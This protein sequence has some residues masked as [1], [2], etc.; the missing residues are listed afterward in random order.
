MSTK[1]V[2]LTVVT[3]LLTLVFASAATNVIVTKYEVSK[4]QI[5][6]GDEF[7]LNISFKHI[8][9]S[10]LGSNLTLV[11][12]SPADF[13]L[14]DGGSS[15][16]I[17]NPPILFSAQLPL[18][19]RGENNVFSFDI[20]DDA[21][22]E[23]I[24]SDKVV[25]KE[26]VPSDKDDDPQPPVDSTKYKPQFELVNQPFSEPF[27]TAKKYSLII[28]LKNASSYV[29]KDVHLSLEK[30]EDE[31]PFD[32]SSSTLTASQKQVLYQN[33]S[34][35]VL[36]FKLDPTALSK[37]YKLVLKI[38]YK[39]TH[40]DS[41]SQT[42]PVVLEVD[43][44]NV[45]PIINVVDTTV[46][47]SGDNKNVAL[48][49]ANG[50]TLTAQDV[51]IA[52][53]GFSADGLILASD[54]AT[55]QIGNLGGGQRATVDFNVKAMAQL[56]GV[57]TLK[58]T[59][60]YKDSAGQQ[61][62]VESEVFI[63]S[64]YGGLMKAIDVK[65]DREQY[66]LTAG[67]TTEVVVHLTNRSAQ[68][69]E[70]LK[71]NVKADGL[72]MMSTYIKLIDELKAGQSRSY[73]FTVSA[74]KGTAKNTYP[75]IAEV[76]TADQETAMVNAVSGITVEDETVTEMG[77]PKVIIDSYDYGGDYIMA[78][79]AFPLTIKLKNTSTTTGIQNVKVSYASDDNVFIPVDSSNA[80][81]IEKIGS[82]EVVTQTVM[83]K[84]KNDAAPKTYVL[85][86][87]IAYEDEKGNAYDAKDNPYEEKERISINLKQQNRLEIAQIDLPPMIMVGEPVN[88]DVNF[89]NMGKSTMYNLLVSGEGDFEMRDATSYVGTFE[90]GKSEYY[91]ATI[92]PQQ[93]GE[94]KGKIS[95]SFEDS[96]GD[97]DVI[98][99][100]L[101]LNVVEGGG[102]EGDEK[103]PG[104][105]GGDE[106]YP[107][108]MIDDDM[109]MTGEG[110]GIFGY[111][112]IAAYVLIP[113][114]IIIVI[115]VLVKRRNRKRKESLLEIDDED[116]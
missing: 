49:L 54:F 70:N 77:K 66:Y 65:F 4:T 3:L 91:S 26:V 42:L 14:A 98:E 22:G 45:L 94:L 113:L 115:I 19:C 57:Q 62:S 35:F 25:I 34:K 12:T 74:D 116:N 6:R 27:V 17:T 67:N 43:N 82:G 83:V 15:V 36:D 64:G 69:F 23:T 51:Q 5:R 114:I 21:T 30:G 63:D 28:Q 50:G 92:I 37:R 13:A 97:K 32:L 41:F 39:N 44:A 87:T 109:N 102:F 68:N 93:P 84:T 16:K 85:E 53:S 101:V 33:S 81:F 18:E 95:F 20:I 7:T 59:L 11:N 103:F 55:K 61:H 38:D 104:E 46:S 76:S 78:G 73:R 111:L 58:A 1:K 108:E 105:M 29:A 107:G 90:P 106:M 71:L 56:K 9:T 79:E 10:T 48:T 80:V 112:K 31:L 47:G 88:I 60:T 99:K 40:G 24:A 8:G 89:F 86:F 96:N 100:E 52:L 75:I 110:D 2:L 72:Q